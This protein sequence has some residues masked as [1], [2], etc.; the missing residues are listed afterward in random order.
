MPLPSRALESRPRSRVTSFWSHA[1]GDVWAIANMIRPAATERNA[2]PTATTFSTRGPARSRFRPY[3]EFEKK[4]RAFRLPGP[5]V[6]WCK[7]PF[8]L[9][10]TLGKKAPADYDYPS[11]RTAL[12]GHRNS[13][14]RRRRV[15]RVR[16]HG[17]PLFRRPRA[18]FQARKEA[19][20][21]RE[22][23]GP[24]LHSRAR[25]PRPP[26]PSHSRRRSCTRSRRPPP[27]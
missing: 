6:E 10:Y 18:R 16:A 19:R 8:V 4:E 1:P 22:R 9:L 24:E 2:S 25:L 5:P 7:T 15:H 23:E 12:R 20:G 26:R 27:R 17:K 13:A 14:D 11:T 3:E 21:T